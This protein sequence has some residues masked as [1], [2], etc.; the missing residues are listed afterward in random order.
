M[1]SAAQKTECRSNRPRCLPGN[2]NQCMDNVTEGRVEGRINVMLV[3]DEA[4]FQDLVRLVLSFDARFHVCGT[5][6]TGEHGL[7]Q[8]DQLAPDLVLVDFRLPG[9]DGLE[10]TRQMKER[11]PDVEIV[12]VTAH[13][14]EVLAKLAREADI[15][16]VIPK[17]SFSLERILSTLDL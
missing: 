1:W 3:E 15:K 8:F 14:E 11:R 2:E 7:E 10:T 12:M 4:G 16:G 9:I 13:T 17:A 5:A 6:M